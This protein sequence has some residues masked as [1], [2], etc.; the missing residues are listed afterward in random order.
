MQEANLGYKLL[1]L[2]LITAVNGFFAA[3]EVALLSTRKSKLEG[4]A[5]EGN[6]GAQA[7][8][9]LLAN[10]SRL[11]SVVQV[12]ISITS[13]G[14]AVA[15]EDTI[16]AIF[17]RVLQP[18]ATPQ[19]TVFLHGLSFV[20]AMLVL[21]V[22]L[23]V[24]GE[25]VPKNIGIE[26][27][28]KLAVLA[29]PALLVFFRAAEPFVIFVERLA[30]WISR[31]L[32]VQGHGHS[33]AHSAEELKYIVTSSHEEGHL[34]GFEQQ[35]M[36]RLLDLGDLVARE[37][38]VPRR[39]AVSIP[40][41]SSLDDVLRAMTESNHSRIPV[42]ED[43]PENIIGIVHFRDLLQVWY[44]RRLSTQRRSRVL[45]FE[46]RQHLRKPMVVPETK[47]VNQLIDEFREYHAH[48]AIVVDEFGTI[49]GLLTFEDV[50][51]QVFGEIEDEH[52]LRRDPIVLEAPLVELEG[53][54]PIRDLE[55]QYGIVL[56]AEAG[57]ETLAGF[58]LF[59]FGHIPSAGEFIEEEARRYTVLEMDRNRIAMVRVER[60]NEEESA[61]AGAIPA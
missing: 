17:E 14:L 52:D 40:I 51:E 59:R 23:V 57:F 38:M 8:L 19:T 30:G 26:R 56:P 1:L 29:A 55:T 42:W 37:I 32:G 13:L 12:G 11:L 16:F 27:A 9:K 60:L 54:I 4:L 61:P 53:S 41:G 25:V 44:Q 33:G 48:M 3:A 21:T 2:A 18:F 50:L 34:E 43:Q 10:P 24:G 20:L 58:L 22:V 15:G 28:D 5:Q 36:Q 6:L 49:V 35:A 7:A 39:D 45:P 31:L 47:P 46:L